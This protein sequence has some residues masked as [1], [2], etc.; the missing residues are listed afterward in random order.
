MSRNRVAI[1]MGARK[2][3][4]LLK[5]NGEERTCEGR[6]ENSRAMYC[7]RIRRRQRI[8]RSFESG[9]GRCAKRRTCLSVRVLCHEQT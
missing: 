3:S 4:K 1:E 7:P 2:L 8:G 9:E 5:T 6:V